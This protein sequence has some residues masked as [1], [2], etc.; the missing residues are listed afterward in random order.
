MHSDE[1]GETISLRIQPERSDYTRA[2]RRRFWRSL[3][4]LVF[5]GAALPLLPIVRASALRA[6]LAAGRWDAVASAAAVFLGVALFLAFMV[7]LLARSFA[8]YALRKTPAALQPQ[9]VTFKSD[10]MH[11]HGSHVRWSEF[12]GAEETRSAFLL[13]LHAGQYM[14]LPRRQIGSATEIRRMLRKYLG[15]KARVR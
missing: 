6:E 8:G 11:A 4:W 12:A 9:M 3:G 10:G 1:C 14:L 5:A 15:G 13:E 2:Y 7:E